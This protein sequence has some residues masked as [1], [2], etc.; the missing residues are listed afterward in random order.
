MTE[1]EQRNPSMDVQPVTVIQELLSRGSKT[2]LE[3]YIKELGFTETLHIFSRL[4]EE[5]QKK[6][7]LK[8][9]TT[10]AAEFLDDVPNSL[11]SEIVENLSA[12]DA[13]PI[14]AEMESSSKADLLGDISEENAEEIL[15]EM[16]PQ[17]ADVLR[18]LSSYDDNEA[19]GLM[20]T[21]IITFDM[22]ATVIDVIDFL[23]VLAKKDKFFNAYI[24]ITSKYGKLIGVLGLKDLLIVHKSTKLIDISVA[25]S[26]V[27]TNFTIDQLKEFFENNDFYGVPVVDADKRLVGVVRRR[28]VALAVSEY[29]AAKQLRVAGIIEGE[30]IRTMPTLIRSRRRLSWLSIN[31]VLNMISAS[32]IALYTDTLTAVIALAVFLPIVS[33]MS[34]CSGNQ[35]V[36][37]S[38]R[39]LSLGLVKPVEVLRVWFQEVKVGLINGCMLGILLGGLAW[40][41]K[42]NPYLGVVIG[43]A[44]AINTMIAVSI[45]GTIPLILKRMNIDPA[46]ASGPVLTTVTD[47]CGFFLVL[48]I[49]T[50][51]LPL[52]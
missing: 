36:A 14:V 30:E 13:A 46:V 12:Q 6:L 17:E 20:I 33:D 48:S 51:M 24:Y 18:E 11:V 3:Q 50:L 41:W 1:E 15:A 22:T 8:I 27:Q 2:E 39:E 23:L 42:G 25:P 4:D 16:S 9:S 34:G 21:E 38:M 5:E 44:L 31:I 43:S 28:D 35:A 37:V 29:S 26:Y 47:L 7:L 52:L 49:A 40:L 32:V 10:D 19:G 45:G